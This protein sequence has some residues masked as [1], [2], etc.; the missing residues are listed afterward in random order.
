[1]RVRKVEFLEER[2]DC[3]CLEVKDNHNFKVGLG[4][5]V[6]NSILDNFFIPT[7]SDGRGSDITTVGGNA[8]GFKNLD[9]LFYF[10]KLLYRSLKYPLSRVEKSSEGQSSDVLFGGGHAAEITRDEIKWAKF[11]ERQ[12]NILTK[13]LKKLF[14]LHLEFK[15]LKK[16]YGLEDTDFHIH[17]TAPSHYKESMEQGYLAQNFDN[18]NAL[19]NNAE[20]SKYYL[21]K[22]Y[23]HWNEDEINDNVKGL[24]KDKDLFGDTMNQFG[25][26]EGGGGFDTG[27]DQEEQGLIGGE[28]TEEPEEQGM[29]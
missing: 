27:G 8:E 14:L 21:M 23:L 5:Y 22:K 3:G 2:A 17:M 18:Y 25:G 12:Q 16:Q 11:L 7:S 24:E 13:E 28:M 26:G 19:S 29:E 9:D 1:M 6:S 15:G 10:Q 20:F 4:V